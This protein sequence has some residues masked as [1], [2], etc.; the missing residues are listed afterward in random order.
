MARFRYSLQSIL[1]I[2]EKLENQERQGFASAQANLAAEEEKLEALR[3][4]L[5]ACEE[6]AKSLLNGPLDVMK[7]QENKAMQIAL[8]DYVGQ[9]KTEVIRAERQLENARARLAQVRT[10]RR[11][12]ETLREQAFA[13]FLQEENKEEGKAV[14]ELVSYTFGQKRQEK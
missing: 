1:N 6:E 9:Q 4:D 3:R 2:K 14:D 13:E 10:E 8:T 11:T 7:I 5:E 12:Y